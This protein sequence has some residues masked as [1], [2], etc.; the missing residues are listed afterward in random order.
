M[1]FYSSLNKEW[2]SD[3]SYNMDK[4]LKHHPKQSKPDMKGRRVCDSGYM[5]Y[6]EQAHL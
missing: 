4:L 1:E 6:L 3:T 5:R 2:N